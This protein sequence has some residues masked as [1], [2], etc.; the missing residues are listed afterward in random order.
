MTIINQLYFSSFVFALITFFDL[1]WK[2]RRPIVLK[3]VLLLLVVCIGT[4]SFIHAQFTDATNFIFLF[5]LFKAIIASAFM[6]IFSILYF[7]KFNGTSFASWNPTGL[8]SGISGYNFSY[9]GVI[10][11]KLYT[12]IS[13]NATGTRTMYSFDGT[14]FTNLS[15][16]SNPG[17]YYG[18]F[19]CYMCSTY[20]IGGNLK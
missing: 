5:I 17:N 11:N 10:N 13:D 12:A 8:P 4:A 16:I 19:N 6:L 7:P 2:F 1:L 3:L 18:G 15:S 9:M 14:A 20:F